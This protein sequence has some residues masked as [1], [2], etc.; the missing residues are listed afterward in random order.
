MAF[1]YQARPIQNEQIKVQFPDG[2]GG[3]NEGDFQARL[4]ILSE[5]E[6]QSIYTDKSIK[7]RDNAILEQSVET[8]SGIGDE[9]G[10]EYPPERQLEIATKLDPFLRG[11]L[12]RKLTDIRSKNVNL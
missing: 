5:K 10:E 4:V 2:S 3:W 7:N 11:A 6:W 8:V 12:I 9:H 1:V